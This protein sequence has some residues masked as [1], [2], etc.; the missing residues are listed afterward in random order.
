MYLQLKD[1]IK[2]QL[3]DVFFYYVGLVLPSDTADTSWEPSIVQTKL[4][5]DVL[6]HCLLKG[7]GAMSVVR[8]FRTV[9]QNQYP[10]ADNGNVKQSFAS[11]GRYYVKYEYHDMIVSVTLHISGM[12]VVIPV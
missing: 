10:I 3:A 1:V 8:L 4:G 6:A 9:G 11:T 7:V 5:G 12:P 2:L